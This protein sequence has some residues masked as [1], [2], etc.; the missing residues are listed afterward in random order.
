MVTIRF[1]ED[2]TANNSRRTSFKTGQVVELPPD[3]ANRWLSR[4]V[5]ERCNNVTPEPPPNPKPDL[6]DGLS[7]KAKQALTDAGLTSAEA[8]AAYVA[9][10]N[11]LVALPGIGES[12]AKQLLER[13]A[14]A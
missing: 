3:A 10:G 11:D 9:E 1:L 13:I 4:R 14:N 7:S 2:V 5:A 6:L 12:T 8:V